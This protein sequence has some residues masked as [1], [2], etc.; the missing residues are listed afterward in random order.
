MAKTLGELA[1]LTG[2]ELRGKPA[3]KISGVA[4]LTAAG[5][6]DIAFLADDHYLP[7]LKRCRAGAVILDPAHADAC[8]G[9]AL[10]T[11]NPHLAFARIAQALYPA[12]TPAA[13]I[14]P[15]AVVHPGANVASTASI[16]AHCVVGENATIAARACLGPHCVVGDQA[17]VGEDT[18]LVAHVVLLARCR[19]GK[20]GLV[21]PGAVIG[22]D[23]FGFARDGV[24]WVKVP[25]LGR[26]IIGDDVEIGA[27]TAVDRGALNDTVIG[28]GVKLDNLIQVAH[29]VQIGE[30]TALAGQAG[31]AGSAVIGKRCTVGGQA[32]ILGHLEMTDD[33]HVTAT[34]LV[35]KS[36]Q[37]PGAYS[38]SLKALP[39]ASWRR[40][41]ARLHQIEALVQRVTELEKQ[42]RKL[43]G[44][45][46]V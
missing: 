7:Q 3:H 28:D 32:V 38:S 26:V 30:H 44:E 33:V 5:P 15:S 46:S 42:I 10:L 12:E 6:D 8:P 14:H 18:R 31:V 24:R 29:N 17:E 25:Q 1:R 43:A 40:N 37:E 34:S 23:G 36:L 41:V 20:R 21:H 39:V 16:G 27:N 11:D 19:I 13:G 45:E 2:G 9:N 35:T 4:T 22:A